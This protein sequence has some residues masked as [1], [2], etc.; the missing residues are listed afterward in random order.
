MGTASRNS[1]NSIRIAR[2]KNT[3]RNKDRDPSTAHR[4]HSTNI[5]NLDVRSPPSHSRL[6]KA[7]SMSGS[8]S[9]SS[10]PA[11]TRN[12]ASLSPNYRAP[13]RN[14]Y[15]RSIAKCTGMSRTNRKRAIRRSRKTNS[16][17][18]ILVNLASSSRP[19]LARTTHKAKATD[20]LARTPRD[21]KY[22]SRSNSANDPILVMSVNVAH[23]PPAREN[24]PV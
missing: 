21:P 16:C 22:L 8:S 20:K 17:I 2:H 7:R 19:H 15:A 12:S 5:A 14:H 23:N 6:P 1:Y 13:R 4:A 11:Y 3:A 9:T 10:D 18:S 24:V